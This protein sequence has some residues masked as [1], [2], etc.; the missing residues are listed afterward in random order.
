MWYSTLPGSGGNV[1]W[2]V[3]LPTDRAATQNQTDLYVAIWFGMA[4]YDPH[5]LWHQCFLELQ[6]YPDQTWYNPGPMFPSLTVNGAWIAQAVAWEINATSG[7]EDPCYVQPLYLN[8]VPGPAFLNMTQGDKIS[9]TMKGWSSSTIGE[10][11]WTNDTTNGQK[12]IN[13][14]YNKGQ[15]YPLDPVY[16]ASNSQDDLQWGLGGQ[17]PVSFS[18]ETGHSWNP[19]QNGGPSNIYGGCNPGLPGS[20]PDT[21]CGTFDPGSW[22]NDTLTPWLIK[23]PVFFNG[24]QSVT[25]GAQVAFEQDFGGINQINLPPLP[26]SCLG[27]VA[28]AWCSYPWYS[29]SCG[30][31]AFEFGA[32]NYPGVSQDFG[33][34]KQFHLQYLGSALGVGFSIPTNFTMPTCGGPTSTLMVMTSGGGSVNFLSTWLASGNSVSGLAPGNYSLNAL[35]PSGMHFGSWTG[36]AGVVVADVNT[37]WTS[38]QISGAGGTLTANFVSVATPA[39][40]TLA[41]VGGVG[42]QIS[43]TT[44]NLTLAPLLAIGGTGTGVS[45]PAGIYSIQA[46]PPVGYN[47]TY[48]TV[49]GGTITAPG[50]AVS[51]GFPIT[52]LIV[53]AGGAATVTAHYVASGSKTPITLYASGPGTI[54]LGSLTATGGYSGGPTVGSAFGIL[55]VGQYTLGISASSTFYYFSLGY[56][57]PGVDLTDWSHQGTTGGSIHLALEN[58]SPAAT[59]IEV[60]FTQGITFADS[61]A[62]AGMILG[63]TG[64]ELQNG[65]IISSPGPTLVTGTMVA[66]PAT[67]YTFLDWTNSTPLIPFGNHLD[68]NTFFKTGASGTI[69]ANYLASSGPTSLTFNIVTPAG[70]QVNFNGGWVTN[71]LVNASVATGGV[72]FVSETTNPDYSFTGWSS[73]GGVTFTAAPWNLGIEV[74]VASAGTLTATFAPALA[75]ISF[76]ASS[77]VTV[78]ATVGGVTMAIDHTQMLVPGTSYPLVIAPGFGFETWDASSSITIA[79]PAA[80]STTFTFT[81]SGTIYALVIPIPTGVT[82]A[83]NPTE[84][85]VT[86]V[87]SATFAAPGTHTYSWSALPPGCTSSN[88]LSLSCSPTTAGTY[89][90]IISLIQDGF[91][92]PSSPGT[93]TVAGALT[94][95]VASAPGTIDL[96]QK[97]T[98]TATL[99]NGLSPVTDSWSGLPAGC[100]SANLLVLPC[101]PTAAGSFTVHFSGTDSVGVVA[102]GTVALTVNPIV[103][104]TLVVSPVSIAQGASVTFT[105]AGSGGSG[106]YTYSYAGLPAGCTTMNTATLTC[107]PTAAGSVTV[108]VTATDALGQSATSQAALIV[109]SPSPPSSGGTFLGLP[110]TE[111]YA[112][113]AGIIILIA[114]IIIAAAL[115]MRRKKEQ[116]PPARVPYKTP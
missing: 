16:S 60:F 17:Y 62:S 31:G 80:P 103:A 5:G 6:F 56:G 105:A 59:F 1:T 58:G 28:S 87:I 88:S 40:V 4:L 97:T 41:D 12:S 112:L 22:A 115:L 26:P 29:Y 70:G 51:S 81:G 82:A 49:T 85:G 20:S 90:P 75:G 11:I 34:Y 104:V 50:N 114:A 77:L 42:G 67:G 21:P 27:T 57:F 54:T 91:T 86:T 74:K 64:T 9:I 43:V 107:T 93:V 33:K 32:T 7:V 100:P 55:P 106:S 110:A 47:F 83:P 94:A 13:T 92:L 73:S 52:N 3:T 38:V 19:T 39:L 66:Q 35:A 15:N 69:T 2:S 68:I 111:G 61:P 116:P 65:T 96:G 36:S 71:G 78:T 18:Y 44:Y 48:W 101:T 45:L 46:Y 108:T 84:V 102:T 98:L 24:A 76:V 10:Q 23:P 37:P 8:G 30:A 63:P 79:N 89:T 14:L 53:D 72:Y 95:A 25:G 99:S 109:T 113:L